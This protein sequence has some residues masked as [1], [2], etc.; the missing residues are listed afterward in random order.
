MNSGLLSEKRGRNRAT[1]YQKGAIKSRRRNWDRAD[2]KKHQKR[3]ENRPQIEEEE[4][5]K[6][7]SAQKRE[8]DR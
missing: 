8:L 4:G 2:Q 3:R 6:R 1:R 7:V 5:D